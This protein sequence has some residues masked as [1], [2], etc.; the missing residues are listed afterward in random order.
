MRKLYRS[1]FIRIFS[2]LIADINKILKPKVLINPREK[3]PAEYYNYLDV[4]SRILAE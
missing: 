3:L 2:A 4:F 1:N